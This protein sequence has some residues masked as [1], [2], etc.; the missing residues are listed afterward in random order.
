MKIR[1]RKVRKMP[2]KDFA[3]G[4]VSIPTVGAVSRKPCYLVVL[5]ASGKKT[6]NF[7]SLDKP[8]LLNG[9][10]QTKGFFTDLSEDDLVTRFAEVVASTPKE[11]FLDMMFPWHRVQS[12]RSLVFNAVKPTTPI[13]R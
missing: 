12:I 2:E 6:E 4:T 8:D 13:N 10:I 1:R 7:V 3:V 5:S 9:F 11:T